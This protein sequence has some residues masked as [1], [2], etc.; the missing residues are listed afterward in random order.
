MPQY[1]YKGCDEEGIKVRGIYI[2]GAT[3]LHK[4]NELYG[5]LTESWTWENVKS[6]IESLQIKN[7]A[8]KQLVAPKES[9]S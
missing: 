2:D 5:T 1:S 3:I 9:S 8:M 4:P 6:F 7:S